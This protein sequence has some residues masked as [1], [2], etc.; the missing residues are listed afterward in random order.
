MF[1]F[2][3]VKDKNIKRKLDVIIEELIRVETQIDEINQNGEKD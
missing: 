1:L 2:D 3:Y